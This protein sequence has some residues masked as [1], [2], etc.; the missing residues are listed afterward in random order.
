MFAH[1]LLPHAARLSHAL[2][3]L[4]V[5]N[6]DTLCIL[7]SVFRDL[8][9]F[10]IGEATNVVVAGCSAGGLS[11]FLNIDSIARLLPVSARVRGVADAGYF[12]DMVDQSGL[13]FRCV[14]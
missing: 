8:L 10:G 7:S 13:E 12:I 14:I 1:S 4:F 2:S 3:A 5:L 11:V 9:R 6:C